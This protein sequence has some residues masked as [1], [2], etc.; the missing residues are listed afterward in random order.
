MSTEDTKLVLKPSG[1]LIVGGAIVVAVTTA[2]VGIAR[3]AQIQPSTETAADK[4]DSEAGQRTITALGR[5]E[6]EGEVVKVGGPAG[7]RIL[8]LLVQEGQQVKK[9][10]AIAYLESYPEQLAAHNLAKSQFKEAQD[11]LVS[12]QQLGQVQVQEAETRQAQVSQ[13]KVAE[14]QA[15]AA[16][17]E[18]LK[19]ELRL[20]EKD[21]RRFQDLQTG[22][23]ISRK[24]LDDR[25]LALR[26]RQEEL[27]NAIAIFAQLKQQLTT[28]LANATT[29]VDMAKV[30][31]IK[32]QIQTQV[33][34]AARNLELTK[35]RLARSIIAAPQNGQILEVKLQDGETIPVGGSQGGGGEPTIVE[36]GNTNQMV[37]VAEIYETD[38]RHVRVGQSAT[39][40]S[41]AFEGE[42]R[43]VVKQV[44][45]QI[46]KN[47]VLDTDPAANTD[48]RVVEVKI[49]LANGFPVAKL[50][51]LQ[52]DVA[53]ESQG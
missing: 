41:P 36:M 44:G 8:R 24:E 18:R 33:A 34:S 49:G 40:K 30:G 31:T 20:A 16:T 5:V 39:V 25:E 21:Y 32:S 52:V 47:D 19:A 35:A 53:I 48:A 23:A 37:V 17:I 38:I 4:K 42:L 9:G 22:G 45:L 11:L 7:E 10:Q 50:T 28:D 3:V 43:G 15:Q 14:L 6:P 12:E 1:K 46:D 13:P 27:K 26:S 29:Q 2:A 51:N